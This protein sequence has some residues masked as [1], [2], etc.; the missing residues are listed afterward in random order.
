MRRKPA[1]QSIIKNFAIDICNSTSSVFST[2]TLIQIGTTWDKMVQNGTT[3][4]KMVQILQNAINAT[5]CYNML[6]NATE[7]YR[8]LQNATKCD[9][10][11]QNATKSRQTPDKKKT[12]FR[13]IPNKLNFVV[14]FFLTFMSCWKLPRRTKISKLIREYELV[15]LVYRILRSKQSRHRPG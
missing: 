12:N 3:C 14:R 9:K 13:Q 7:C 15:K 5:K 2:D 8:M 11:P 6:Q 10:M 4:Y 1:P